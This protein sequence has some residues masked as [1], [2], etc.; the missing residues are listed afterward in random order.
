MKK[1][2]MNTVEKAPTAKPATEE[3]TEP[4]RPEM[5]EKLVI[6]R[7]LSSSRATPSKSGPRAGKTLISQSLMLSMKPTSGRVRLPL[8][9]S[10]MMP[11]TT[12]MICVTSSSRPTMTMISV[13][14][15]RSQ[16]G[17]DL[18]LIRHLRSSRLTGWPTSDTTKAAMI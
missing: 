8:A 12:G 14:A 1:K 11:P 9:A 7:N 16:S 6:S 17:A 10:R 3:A 13:S 4:S 5:A 2:E 18:P 15:A